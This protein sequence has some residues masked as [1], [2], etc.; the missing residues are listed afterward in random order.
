MISRGL[1][2]RFGN[3]PAWIGAAGLL[4]VLGCAYEAGEDPS[5]SQT[6]ASKTAVEAVDVSSFPKR[7]KVSLPIAPKKGLFGQIYINTTENREYIYDGADW[8]P[9]DDGVEEYYARK[10]K[11]RSLA[12]EQSEVCVDGDPACTPTG[13][14]GKHSSFDCRVCHNVGG[15]LAFQLTG[16]AYGAAGSPTP[17]FDA[18]AK[19][20]SNVA[21][22]GVPAGT[23]S[24]Y[25]PG[26][27]MD[28]DGYP[29]PEL[30]TVNYG[31][32]MAASTPSWYAT[33]AGCAACHGNPPQNGSDGSNAWHRNH[34]NNIF[35]GATSCELCHNK[36]V[37]STTYSPIAASSNGV[38]TAILIPAMHAD[39]F[40]SI[41]ARFES[42][43][44]GC[45]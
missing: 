41:V 22:H 18:T 45:H 28:A 23:F 10:G 30:K 14:H 11:G 27:E 35:A 33:G 5:S 24:Y 32:T 37:G 7:G 2:S 13:A 12:L 34:A 1:Y 20:C 44:F 15:R 36:L 40:I 21:C 38:G 26:N 3:A 6:S 31:G 25:F 29:I 42:R 8:V 39:G 43:C 16:P 19:T 9:H 17:T 4:L